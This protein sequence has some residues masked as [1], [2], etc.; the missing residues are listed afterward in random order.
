MK[1]VEFP[2]SAILVMIIVL[3]VGITLLYIFSGTLNPSAKSVTLDIATKATCSKISLFTD[4]MMW[5]RIPVDD[6]DA[7][8][9]GNTNDHNP[10]GI[11]PTSP[12]DDNLE[13]LCHNFYYCDF[14]G[15]DWEKWRKC[16]IIR[17][18]GKTS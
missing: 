12:N 6:F 4:Q 9:N 16:C 15:L 11:Y 1:G 14:A 7:N 13:T 5:A 3:A 17:I 10:V 8:G 18:C 2:I